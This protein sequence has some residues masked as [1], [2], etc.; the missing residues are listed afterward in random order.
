VD[1]YNTLGIILAFFIYVYLVREIRKGSTE[2]NLAT[3]TSWGLLD[4][5]AGISLYVQ[6]GNWYLLT[7]YIAGSI[8]I[9]LCILQS[10][11]FQWGAVEKICLAL[12]IVSILLWTQAGPWYAT[13][14]STAGIAIA[15]YPQ[16]KDAIL[17]PQTSPIEVYIGF[18][19]VNALATAGGK[20]WT[21]EERLYPAVCTILCCLIVLFSLRKYSVKEEPRGA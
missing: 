20:A 3:W 21:I 8:V 14:I 11:K 5:V 15:T 17:N 2:Q 16:L 13:I 12:V 6:G 9:S 1:I 4:I 19:I 10:A 7:I 18:T